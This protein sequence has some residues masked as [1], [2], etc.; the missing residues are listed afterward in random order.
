MAGGLTGGTRV[1]W[2]AVTCGQR[3]ACG[4]ASPLVVLTRPRGA[5]RLNVRVSM[6]PLPSSWAPGC[7]WPDSG[8]ELY[9]ASA[10][11]K[12]WR[13]WWNS[14]CVLSQD[15][16]CV[17][18]CQGGVGDWALGAAQSLPQRRSGSLLIAATWGAVPHV[19]C[20]GHQWRVRG[21]RP[22]QRVPPVPFVLRPQPRY[23]PCHLPTARAPPPVCV[24]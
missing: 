15:W 18:L 3:N 19:Q 4:L 12:S 20:H 6:C 24:G 16:L 23:G 8:P 22:G 13:N 5:P 9:N 10:G 11:Y 17:C 14:V 21:G 2:S 1:R 7:T